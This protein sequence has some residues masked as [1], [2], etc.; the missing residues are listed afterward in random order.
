MALEPVVIQ[1]KMPEAPG[2]VNKLPHW[3]WLHIFTNMRATKII[4]AIS[5][6]VISI[7][8]VSITV[9]TMLA[10][11]QSFQKKHDLNSLPK[12]PPQ[13]SGSQKSA[14]ALPGGGIA[15][16]VGGTTGTNSPVITLT[17]NPA[18][19][20]IGGTSQLKWSVTNNPSSCTASDDW[21]GTKPSSGSATTPKLT[22]SQTYL[23][24]LTCQ[25]ATGT[26][27]STVSVGTITESGGTG[28]VA[29]RPAVSFAASPTAI[30][31]GD[32]STLI[33]S[34]T[35]NPTSCTA[36]GDWSGSK[37]NAGPQ[38]TGALSTA[39]QYN[40]TLQCSNSAG[41]SPRITVNVL[42]TNPPP[43]LP[44]V[45][46]AAN[47]IGPITPGSS[48]TLTWS[49]TNNPTSCTA[50]GDWS[51]SKPGSGSASSG[52]LNSVRDYTFTLTCS[53]GS[54]STFA[55]A[56]VQVLPNPPAVS[57][58]LSPSA[59]YVGNS[60]T[61]TW[62]VSNTTPATTCTAS[63]DWSGGITPTNG[64]TRSTGTLNDARTFLYSLSCTN[65]GGT[66]FQKNVPL[67][68]TLPPPPSASISVSP[69]S[70]T[71]GQ[72]ATIS[73]TASN[74]PTS[75]ATGSDLTGP[76]T[77]LSGGSKST[78]T[79]TTQ[80]TYTYAL[81]CTNAGG[82][83]NV[84]KAT[85]SVGSGGGSGSPPVVTIAVSPT[86]ISTG[87]SATVSWS[88]TNNPTSCS[89]GGTT[90]NWVTSPGASGS[91][92]TGN[93]SN[94]GTYTYSITCTNSAGSGTGT[95]NPP[96]TVGS[97]PTV[98]VSLGSSSITV[99][100]S[101]T[102]SWSSTAA[103]SCSGGGSLSGS[104]ATSGGPI[105]T[106]TM[107][108][109]G[110]YNYTVTCVNSIGGSASKTAILTVNPAQ[111]YCSGAT[112]C[113]GHSQLVSNGW[114]YIGT[115]IIDLINFAPHHCCGSGDVTS[116][117]G[118][119]VQSILNGSSAGN[120]NSHGHNGGDVNILLN[121]YLISGTYDPNKP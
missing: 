41:Q 10:N 74:N 6:I 34:V 75:C 25:T 55:S 62:N 15:T 18:S 38:S 104:M 61:I 33:W 116:S 23:F 90:P 77:P 26:G 78:G 7:S 121:S 99:G 46:M 101:T 19:V 30:Y 88:A 59:L 9:F 49:T 113:Y 28:S 43:G 107:N 81:Q 115:K 95:T 119:N 50:S 70:I 83:S 16:G 54:G 45:R 44:I 65:E 105:T 110:T 71:S 2:P 91:T 85:L 108:T 37:P 118:M 109:A 13:I 114:G 17:A 47:P 29:N 12:P 32:S 82:S 79:L 68:V 97:L 117:Y 36:S 103:S 89:A 58:T 27:F 98:S 20:G 111:A 64:G 48:T 94:A 69:I 92:S 22:K 21:S 76:I 86:S 31:T 93:I 24:T 67:T 72:S 57:L 42:V 5:A 1:M 4:T 87:G 39:R 120:G 102:Y 56:D 80:R 14:A 73:W 106:G 112:P 53:N 96:L 84:A 100:S 60:S 52:A 51:G 40:Y 66:G 11:N 8:M 35:N 3:S 63:G